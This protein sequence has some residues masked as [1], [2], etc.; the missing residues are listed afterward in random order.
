MSPVVKAR[1]VIRM[2]LIILD[3]DENNLALSK[4]AV[5]K[6]IEA[7]NYAAIVTATTNRKEA[8]KD[9]DGVLCTIE[10]SD[11]RTTASDVNVP[12]KYGI[13]VNIGDTRGPSAIFRFLRTLP[14]M[15]DR[16]SVV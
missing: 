16:K 2:Q 6:I 12:L 1:Q 5:D 15:I 9:A 8:L 4:K 3:I 10:C 7:G 13:S 14:F 11:D